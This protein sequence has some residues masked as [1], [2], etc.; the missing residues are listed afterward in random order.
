MILS[1]I[2][3]DK[4]KIYYDKFDNG[5]GSDKFA[6]KGYIKILLE[7]NQNKFWLINTHLQSNYDNLDYSDIRK[8]QI[9]QI[10][11][12]KDY[13]PT[14]LIGDLNIKCF[15]QE[16]YSYDWQTLYKNNQSTFLEDKAIYDYILLL[17]SNSLFRLKNI[18]IKE[19][20]NLSDHYP[21]ISSLECQ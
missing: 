1:K 7:F 15:S 18:T 13:M 11:I 14:L 3:F 4:N 19:N 8:Q 17:N 20:I 6:N 21:I 10:K 2:P 9:D 5:V 12:Y 16:F